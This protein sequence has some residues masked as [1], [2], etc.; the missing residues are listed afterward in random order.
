MNGIE[1]ES[2]RRS[3]SRA[4]LQAKSLVFQGAHAIPYGIAGVADFIG[5]VQH[6]EI[7]VRAFAT[8]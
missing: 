2:I 1:R 5:I 8:L 7:E 6:N 4:E 3:W